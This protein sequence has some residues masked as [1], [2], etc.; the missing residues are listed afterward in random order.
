[1]N[2]PSQMKSF[3]LINICFNSI[4]ISISYIEWPQ[5]FSFGKILNFNNVFGQCL[6]MHIAH[7]MF[8]AYI[9]STTSALKRILLCV[10]I[11]YN[12]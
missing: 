4:S 3:Q 2:I 5:M 6:G 9:N 11:M 7:C 1:M 10:L 12:I 8:C